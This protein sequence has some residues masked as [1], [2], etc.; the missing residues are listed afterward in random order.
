MED[1]EKSL[2]GF[3]SSCIAAGP[4]LCALANFTGPGTT[5]ADLHSALNSAL[6]TLLEN[7]LP[8]PPH[9]AGFVW[10]HTPSTPLY[11]TIK[12]FIFTQL[13]HASRYPLLAAFLQPVLAKKFDV[14]LQPQPLPEPPVPYNLGTPDAFWGIACT[15]GTYR[16]KSS[17][18]MHGFV[19]VQEATSNMADGFVSKLWPC[20]QW[21]MKA[22]ERY[23]GSFHAKTKFP[24]LFVN[25]QYDPCTPMRSAQTASSG[26]EG[27]VVLTHGGHGHKFFRHPSICTTKAVR[28]Y[29]VDGTLPKEGTFCKSDVNAFEVF[30]AGGEGASSSKGGDGKNESLKARGISDEEDLKLLRKMLRH[31]ALDKSNL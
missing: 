8:T 23:E 24:I 29:F 19:R 16:A 7:P 1:T 20:A 6:T 28:A 9:L 2:D 22:A 26:F 3:F 21:K 12:A 13:Y 10:N 5:V 14:L 4:E 15:D 18:D 27:S 30:T 25:G 17:E 31:A 11:N